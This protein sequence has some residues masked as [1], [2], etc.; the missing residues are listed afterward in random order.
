MMQRR[1]R[2]GVVQRKRMNVTWC[3]ALMVVHY[4][5]P[6]SIEAVSWQHLVIEKPRL[7]C[8]MRVVMLAMTA[9]VDSYSINNPQRIIV[10]DSGNLQ[11]F[12]VAPPWGQNFPLTNDVSTMTGWLSIKVQKTSFTLSDST[13]TCRLEFDISFTQAEIMTSWWHHSVIIVDPLETRNIHNKRH[14]DVCAGV[15]IL[16][17]GGCLVPGL[18]YKHWNQVWFDLASTNQTGSRSVCHDGSLKLNPSD[19]WG[20]VSLMNSTVPV[21]VCVQTYL[22]KQ[23]VKKFSLKVQHHPHPSPVPVGS[24]PGSRYWGDGGIWLVSWGSWLC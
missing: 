23:E 20:R 7:R 10:N 15:D 11:I 12:H 4:V 13:Q 19:I 17:L 5:A 2:M 8:N 6:G 1:R 24:G 16:V 18:R 14:G 9:H 22:T 21:C 3:R